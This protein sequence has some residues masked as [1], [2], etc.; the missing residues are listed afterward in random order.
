VSN[1]DLGFGPFIA[2][3]LIVAGVFFLI[4]G[5][6]GINAANK[7]AVEAGVAYWSVDPK[8]G[9]KEF[10]YYKIPQTEAENTEDS[11][12]PPCINGEE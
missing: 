10:K 7:R 3:L 2:G 12:N 8:T 11:T 5:I 6:R 4:G 9:A 1:D